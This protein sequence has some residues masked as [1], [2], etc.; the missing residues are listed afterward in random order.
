MKTK[1]LK[2]FIVIVFVAG[3]LIFL[4]PYATKW[5]YEYDSKNVV[6]NFLE[7]FPVADQ[8]MNKGE[9]TTDDAIDKEEA[10]DIEEATNKEDGSNKEEGNN[11][12]AT[13]DKEET[14]DN[15]EITDNEEN[16]NNEDTTVNEDDKTTE[17]VA[18]KETDDS[19][20]DS[21]SNS[22]DAHDNSKLNELFKELQ[23][24]NQKIYDER[25]VGLKD[26]SGD[27]TFDFDMKQY[28]LKDDV[29][30]ILWIPRMDL[31]LPIYMGATK[32]NLAKGV[33]IMENTSVPIG[34]TNTNT[35]LAGHRGYR[36]IPMFRNIQSIQ[37]GDKIQITTPFET[38]VYR[39]TE[40]KIV[41]RDEPSVLYIQES[42]EIITLLTCHPYT[43]NEQRY[44]VIAERSDEASDTKENDVKEAEKTENSNP[45]PV[46]VVTDK[47]DTVIENISPVEITPVF[48]EGVGEDI[49][50]YSNT[51]I[52]LETYLPFIGIGVVVLVIVVAW[53]AM[54][55]F[56]GRRKK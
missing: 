17:D 3:L 47:G 56:G 15:E 48:N 42:R 26:S 12:E 34:G 31:E 16:K 45:Q 21:L 46:V 29:I 10:T 25:Q 52:W 27:G 22:T 53:G 14:K 4:Y 1:L 49:G 19:T 50:S 18:N 55:V 37:M 36:G 5:I 6:D 13:T 51:Q 38:L 2:L 20:K 7:Q 35:I 33:G 9:S 8:S 39:V 54:N 24:Y 32:K 40:L 44:I 28:G 23:L 43:R 11:Q 41:P 30:G